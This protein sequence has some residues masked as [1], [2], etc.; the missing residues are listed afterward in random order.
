MKSKNALAYSTNLLLA[1]GLAACS[2]GRLQSAASIKADVPAEESALARCV[3][4]F[5]AKV[6]N[7]DLQPAITNQD[8]GETAESRGDTI[9][10]TKPDKITYDRSFED[11]KII[12]IDASLDILEGPLA[13]S[14]YADHLRLY[15]YSITKRLGLT[16]TVEVIY[17]KDG[18]RISELTRGYF[19]DV[20][21]DCAETPSSASIYTYD[22]STKDTG[23][24]K[25][26]TKYWSAPDKV[27]PS[28][29]N[30]VPVAL[31]KHSAEASIEFIRDPLTFIKNKLPLE[32][33]FVAEA[34]THKSTM[35]AMPEVEQYNPITGQN[36]M[37]V[38]VLFS[39][40]DDA[41]TRVNVSKTLISKSSVYTKSISLTDS[42]SQ[43]SV[44]AELWLATKLD[45]TIPVK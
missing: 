26:S 31:L 42:D 39:D 20:D 1:A 2:T 40:G 37:M 23:Q 24:V 36:E 10:A 9:L 29:S 5:Q 43:E 30:P 8:F 32:D 25:T 35:E 21:N 6:P 7:F 4:R 19:I 14:S 28:T 15:P 44:S 17:V 27:F 11:G 34:S 33:E 41:K 38:A 16:R 13:G 45:E 18:Q 3:A 22:W 12:H